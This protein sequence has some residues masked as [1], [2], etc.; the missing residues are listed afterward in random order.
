MGSCIALLGVL[1]SPSD[2]E[3]SSVFFC[4]F[5]GLNIGALG[6]AAKLLAAVL[7][8]L[9]LPAASWSYHV[10]QRCCGPFGSVPYLSH[11]ELLSGAKCCVQEALITDLRVSGRRHVLM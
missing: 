8:Q 2:R 9:V 5:Y 4:A 1:V 11:C 7:V 10:M 6:I 3:V